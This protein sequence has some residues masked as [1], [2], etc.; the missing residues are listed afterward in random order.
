VAA[1]TVALNQQVLMERQTPVVAVV[2]QGLLALQSYRMQAA[3][4]ALA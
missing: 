4:A 3:P 1:V 2:A